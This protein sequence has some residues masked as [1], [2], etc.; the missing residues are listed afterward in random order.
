MELTRRHYGE[1]IRAALNKRPGW[2]PLG[3]LERARRGRKLAVY[4]RANVLADLERS[5]LLSITAGKE[6]G[7]IR[8]TDAGK[9]A[10]LDMPDDI[11][12]DIY[13]LPVDITQA[14][15]SIRSGA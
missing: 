9:A 8:L 1:L 13:P 7:T 5:G 2:V 12:A 15:A 14:K 3:P 6:T 11:G 10:I 4:R